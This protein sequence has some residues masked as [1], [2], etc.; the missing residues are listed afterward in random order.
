MLAVIIGAL[1][2]R[3]TQ[4]IAVLI[5]SVLAT[6]AA[7]AAP[8]YVA[9]ADGALAGYEAARA[10]PDERVLRIFPMTAVPA[11][12][13]EPVL[14][15]FRERVA[16]LTP[17]GFDAVFSA[18]SGGVAAGPG[19]DVE[20][21]LVFRE[22][23][24]ARVEVTGSCP[25]ATGDGQRPE[26]MIGPHTADHLGVGVGDTLSFQGA[27]LRV[28]GVYRPLDPTDVWWLGDE[29]IRPAAPGEAPVPA[30]GSPAD[31]IFVAARSGPLEAELESRATADLFVPGDLV[32]TRPLDE[33]EAQVTDALT[34]APTEGLSASSGIPTLLQ[35]VAAHREQLT[36]GV[37]LGAGTVV[38]L[39]W[40][41]LFAAVGVAVDDRRSE[42]GLLLLRGVQRRRLWT[43]AIVESAVPVLVAFPL[44]CAVAAFTVKVLAA[45]T[46][47]GAGKIGLG[48]AALAFAGAAA[49]G[50]LAAVLLAQLRSL[51]APVVDLLRRV[52]ART[53]GWRGGIADVLAIAVAAAALVQ[54]HTGGEPS[55]L[56]LV[57]P[58]AGV[59]AVAVVLS[60][61]AMAVAGAAGAAMLRSGRLGPGLA[62]VH[63]ARQQRI[64]PLV[65]LL[66]VVLAMLVF[67]ASARDVATVAYDDRATVETGAARVVGVDAMSRRHLLEAVRSIDPQGAF[68]M[69][70]VTARA[71]RPG[72][73]PVVAVDTA[74]LPA[75]VAPHHSYRMAMSDLTQVLHP[76]AP[77]PSVLLRGR[78]IVL[79]ATAD[80]APEVF[81]SASPRVFVTVGSRSGT[82]RVA[83]GQLGP[84]TADYAVPVPECVS[85]CRLVSIDLAATDV[86]TELKL[87]IAEVRHGDGDEVLLT[88]ADLA[89][90]DSWRVGWLGSSPDAEPDVGPGL[91]L[92]IPES[93]GNQEV[94]AVVADAPYPIPA[95]LTRSVGVPRGYNHP[96]E[97][98][99]GAPILARVAGSVER[100]P[101]LGGRGILVDLEYADRAALGGQVGTEEVWLNTQ[102]PGDVLDRLRAQ[103]VAVR[104]DRTAVA[105][106][107]AFHRQG[108]ALA[109]DV[110][111][112]AASAVVFVGVAGMV[113]VAAVERRERVAAMAALRRQGV[114][115]R[116]VR[117][118]YGW[119]VLVAVLVGGLAATAAWAVA[120]AGQRVFSV[121]R[122]PVPVPD[123]P[124]LGLL[125]AVVAPAVV[126]L[127]VTA[128]LLGLALARAVGR[129]D[130]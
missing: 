97:G 73:A 122:S 94:G 25:A 106:R 115:R 7:A 129:S 13:G 111:F 61:A 24:C 27:P 46:L 98:I 49:V 3:R 29:H 68:A 102:A 104:Y 63:L 43:L 123:W 31:A 35:R 100:M 118:G 38:L 6:A 42:Q 26:V 120:R 89:R 14:A 105:V 21:N 88:G 9:A 64:R 10:E 77:A 62:L 45:Q 20:T 40:L 114:P 28:V 48:A 12:P 71:S 75:V 66:T 92:T 79:S 69:A 37:A 91:H 117:G 33:I 121:E 60:R 112:F 70:V 8:A 15:D 44:G 90:K 11:A 23:V 58:V 19:G 80:S 126:A 103:G 96:V 32:R 87:R 55:G 72:G 128:L 1:L 67:T 124:R 83:V 93:E 50:A 82:R 108:A 47:V 34:D 130:R 17:P 59:L 110:N 39:S 51:S 30:V 125:A 22:G 5:L 2:A 113:A 76:E 81:D 84:G 54:L 99:D 86:T 52:P 57:A 127:V 85:G 41:V 36:A 107:D 56:A 53:R 101:R 74:R 4:A 65:V 119:L 95:V 78:T 18:R 16:R 109:L 116:A